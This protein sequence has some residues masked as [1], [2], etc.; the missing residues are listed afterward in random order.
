VSF[1][2]QPNGVPLLRTR[3][4]HVEF[5]PLIQIIVKR[6][7]HRIAIRIL[8]VANR[9]NAIFI[10]ETISAVHALKKKSGM[11]A[12]VKEV[13]ARH[14]PPMVELPTGPRILKNVE[15]VIATFPVNRA[16]RIK[17]RR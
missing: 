7:G 6:H 4:D 2:N 15:K 12:P 9:R 10:D 11:V 1:S 8:V 17:R 14:V 16:S 13:G 5:L 3:R